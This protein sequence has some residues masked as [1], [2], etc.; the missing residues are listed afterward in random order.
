[1]T[2]SENQ[3]TPIDADQHF[4]FDCNPQRPCFN[5]CCRDLCQVLSPYDILCLKNGL[6][7]DSAVFLKTF[8]QETIGTT[9]G[10]PVISLK[11]DDPDQGKCP[12]VTPQGCRVYAYR[13]ASCRI[14]PLARGVSQT[15]QN[16][17]IREH[18][19]LIRETHCQGFEGTRSHTPAEWM[20]AQGLVAYNRMNDL[21]LP[22]I[23]LKRSQGDG[24]LN[25]ESRRRF[26][27]ALYD[28][29]NFRRSILENRV[30]KAP[31]A[32]LEAARKD[33]EILLLLA[34]KWVKE[35]V[36]GHGTG[37]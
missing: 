36:F 12:F 22:I 21:M 19:A 35:V 33:D 3:F 24:S 4:F 5:R 25:D 28:L 2:F 13:P 7:I 15:G 20:A 23:A 31:G 1:V 10:L 14:Y 8:T 11:S 18:F 37:T 26:C 17:R 32:T 6:G 16:D 27:L 34:M 29:D 9:S 30:L